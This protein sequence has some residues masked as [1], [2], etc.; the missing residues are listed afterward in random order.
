MRIREQGKP[1]VCLSL[2]LDGSEDDERAESVAV[3]VPVKIEDRAE[4]DGPMVVQAHPYRGAP[5][6]GRA[7]ESR[8][9]SGW[10]LFRIPRQLCPDGGSLRL[11]ALLDEAVLWERQYKVVWRGRFPGLEPVA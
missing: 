5:L 6:E 4:D 1:S 8:S 10:L 7:L 9:S 11:C 2:T 3:N